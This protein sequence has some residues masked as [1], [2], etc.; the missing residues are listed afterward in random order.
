MKFNSKE[1][2]ILFMVAAILGLHD[3]FTLPF[4]SFVITLIFAVVLFYISESLF[5]LTLVLLVPQ[6][7]H[8]F[9]KM[10][11]IKEKFTNTNEISER[12]INMKKVSPE[13]FTDL[14]EISQRVETMKK[15]DQ[16]KVEVS[17][18]VD[19][20]LPSGTYPM[21][22]TLSYPK[23]NEET[24][25]TSVD[26]NTNIHTIAEASL[27]AVGTIDSLPKQNPYVP[28]FDEIGLSTALSQSSG[29]STMN[30]SNIKAL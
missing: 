23:F 30:A 19:E 27:P 12:I 28:K 6:V 10:M 24:M 25:G 26:M 7:I 18:V 4:N 8:T 21:E 20:S 17:G 13:S 22:G 16:P 9:N 1:E 3:F 2:Q 29:N 11:G 14:N 15:V 5:M